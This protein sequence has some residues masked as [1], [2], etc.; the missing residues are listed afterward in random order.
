MNLIHQTI[1]E[2]LNGLFRIG[3]THGDDMLL[4]KQKI[5][6]KKIMASGKNIE[7]IVKHR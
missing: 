6:R 1:K 7:L 3:H 2:K 4:P 5:T